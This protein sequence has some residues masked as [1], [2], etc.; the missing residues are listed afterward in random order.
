[1][2]KVAFLLDDLF[3]KIKLIEVYAPS[4]LRLYA[5]GVVVCLLHLFSL[6]EKFSA[7]VS[8]S[9]RHLALLPPSPKGLTGHTNCLRYL[10]SGVVHG[11][12]DF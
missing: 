6:V 10:L 3:K 9:S 1:M 12:F 11:A 5:I 8:F 4:I 2:E 7:T